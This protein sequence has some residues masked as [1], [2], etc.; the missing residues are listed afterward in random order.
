MN[1]FSSARQGLLLVLLLLSV[2]GCASYSN[3][4]APIAADLAKDDLNG[5]L[6]LLDKAKTPGRDRLLFLMNRGM[7]LRMQGE[8]ES[9]N[10]MFSAA[11]QV[12]E[13][14][15]ALSLREQSTA[16][17]INDG[18][19]SY[20]G[21]PYEQVMLNLYS[22]MNYLAL[23]QL[24]QA[25]VE[26]L[27][28]DLR[29]GELAD[30]SL[31]ALFE[32]DPFGRYLTALIY[33]SG[34]EQS[35]AMIAYRSAYEAYRQ[36]QKSY[37]LDLPR[38]LKLDLL[39]T[40]EALGLVEENHQYAKEFDL[41]SWP[42][43]EVLRQQGELIFLFNNGLAPIKIE[44]SVTL[45][46]PP[47][48]QLV[49]VTLPAYLRRPASFSKARL[50]I[51]GLEVVTET[52]ENIEEMAIAEL[53]RNQPAILARATARVMLK[54]QMSK[55]AGKQNDLAGLLV[56]VA[57]LFT[58]RADTRSW[59]SLPASIQLARI[60]LPPGE[61]DLETELLG[62]AGESVKTLTFPQVR[63]AAG[64]MTFISCHAVAEGSLLGRH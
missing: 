39:R 53:E 36:H 61:Y 24:N 43:S 52:F 5:A 63:L 18:T 17:A 42:N 8:F 33:E 50:R 47:R 49:R 29:L 7:L 14:L 57:G 31:G 1:I 37:P 12:V 64:K 38:Q 62:P 3:S 27:Q 11:K 55:Q 6:S 32:S 13:E 51:G 30:R 44:Q 48:G 60:A 4:F 9:S 15:N 16:L 35:D 20:A 28:V 41:K 19:R 56:N 22:A 23:G 10:E 45:P 2:S 54:Y 25:R 58:E 46:V 21:A 40:S 34:G 26:A 59:M